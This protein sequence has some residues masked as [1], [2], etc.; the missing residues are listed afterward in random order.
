MANSYSPAAGYQ[1]I[2]CSKALA[3]SIAEAL[4]NG[5]EDPHGF[6]VEYYDGELHLFAEEGCSPD[7]LPKAALVLIG[8]AVAEAGM[9]F[10]KVGV[11]MYCDK[12]R[13]G[14]FGGYDFLITPQG[15]I[16]YPAIVWPAVYEKAA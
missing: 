6:Q 2:K 5:H 7:A 16:V 14:S 11:A 13:P 15:E 9:F 4:D 12:M 8:Q 3:D 1:T 10:L